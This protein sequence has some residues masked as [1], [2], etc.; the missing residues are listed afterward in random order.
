[1]I[2]NHDEQSMKK[3]DYDQARTK[4]LFQHWSLYESNISVGIN[5]I[6]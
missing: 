3:P 1:M 4:I 6:S 2:M 5:K